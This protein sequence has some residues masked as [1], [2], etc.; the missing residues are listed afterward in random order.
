MD[1]PQRTSMALGV[2]SVTGLDPAEAML[3]QSRALDRAVGAEIH[4]V[5]AH[6]E[7]TGLPDEPTGRLLA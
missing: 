3:D 7:H 5:R 4:Y 1:V 6:A 2:G